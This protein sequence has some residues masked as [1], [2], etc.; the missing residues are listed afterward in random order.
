MDQLDIA[1]TFDPQRG[2]I[3]T[4]RDLRTPVVALSLGGLRRKLETLVLPDEPDIVLRL[5][6][7]ARLERDRRRRPV[8]A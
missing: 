7:G 1:V 5:D 6:R 3:G 4:A 8:A 2:Y